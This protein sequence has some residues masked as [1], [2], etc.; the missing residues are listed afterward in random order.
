M[1]PMLTVA[2]A[3]ACGMRPNSALT[4]VVRI[5]SIPSDNCHVVHHVAVGAEVTSIETPGAIG[6]AT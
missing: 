4:A 5:G 1:S 3:V 6:T 2:K